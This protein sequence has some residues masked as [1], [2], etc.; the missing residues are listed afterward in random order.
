MPGPPYSKEARGAKFQGVLLAEATVMVDERVTSVR[1]VKSPG[2]V[3]DDAVI[4]TL[5]RWIC[6]PAIGPS[7]KLVPVKITFEFNYRLNSGN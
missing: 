7:G 1:I 6:K 2:L 4:K 3:L 5:R